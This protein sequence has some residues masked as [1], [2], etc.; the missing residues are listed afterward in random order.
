MNSTTG[1]QQAKQMTTQMAAALAVLL[2]ALI[3]GFGF[4]YIV[5]RITGGV[6]M[7][8][9]TFFFVGAANFSLFLTW[10]RHLGWFS[11]MRSGGFSVRRWEKALNWGVFFLL[12]GLLSVNLSKIYA[13]YGHLL[14]AFFYGAWE[15]IKMLLWA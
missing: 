2:V 15:L 9:G 13:D 1:F 4:T 11:A 14:K 3:A 5:D 6:V 12:W 10:W 7:R 8:N